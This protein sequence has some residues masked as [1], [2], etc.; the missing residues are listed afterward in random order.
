MG[1]TWDGSLVEI[2]V[3]GALDFSQSYTSGIIDNDQALSFAKRIDLPT[4]IYAGLMDDIR[5]YDNVLSSSDISALFNQSAS[6]PEPS[7]LWMGLLGFGVIA[8]IRWS[9]PK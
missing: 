2:Y 8:W 9:I 3:D 7:T 1:W 6:L 4:N 5:I